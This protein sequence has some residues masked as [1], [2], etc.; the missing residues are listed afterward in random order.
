MNRRDARRTSVVFSAI[1]WTAGASALPNPA[2]D[3]IGAAADGIRQQSHVRAQ[4]LRDQAVWPAFEPR[5]SAEFESD[6]AAFLDSHSP[7]EIARACG[8]PTEGEYNELVQS[9]P[10]LR[11]HLAYNIRDGARDRFGRVIV[12][13]EPNLAEYVARVAPKVLIKIDKSSQWMTVESPAGT[14]RYPVST[15]DPKQR[16]A[17]ETP[18]GCFVPD[19]LHGRGYRALNGASAGAPMAYAIHFAGG[20]AIHA[21]V[22]ANYHLL[23]RR[24]ASHGCVRTYLEHA[25]EINETVAT[26]G[27]RILSVPEGETVANDGGF[28]T[29]VTAARPRPQRFDFANTLICVQ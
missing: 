22:P 8:L 14:K 9:H 18:V 11:V 5:C 26:H 6:P 12:S 3:A 2:G 21:T 27:K 19:A 29:T 23:G 13:P 1:L 24:R 10:G 25:R 7:D 20:A 4:A 16:H 15:G 17:I 28:A